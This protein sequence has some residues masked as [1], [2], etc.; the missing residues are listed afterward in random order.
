MVRDMI[1]DMNRKFFRT[2]LVAAVPLLLAVAPIA[3]SAASFQNPLGNANLQGLVNIILTS[4][5]RIGAV[6][7]VFFLILSG[8]KFVT[9]QGNAGEIKSAKEMLKWTIIGGLI[10]M[11][12]FAISE[13]IKN[14]LC[15]VL[16]AAC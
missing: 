10:T 6:L 16:P 15:S 5:V 13:I 12:A 8:F 2:A 14:T 1:T 4:I 9:A 11:G 3:V 7:C